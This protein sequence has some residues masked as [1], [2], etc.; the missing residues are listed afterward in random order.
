MP[1]G[2]VGRWLGRLFPQRRVTERMIHALREDMSREHKN[3]VREL[4]EIRRTAE[5]SRQRIESALAAHDEAL[6]ALPELQARIDR[7]VTAYSHDAK[8]ATRLNDFRRSVDR[9]QVLAHVTR[10]V[11]RARLELSPCPYLVVE[12]VFPED[13]YDRLVESLPPPVFFEKTND[14]RDEMPV[15]FSTTGIC[16]ALPRKMIAVACTSPSCCGV[17]SISN[18]CDSWKISA[19]T[20]FLRSCCNKK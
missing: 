5:Q 19:G 1:D 10:A 15:P 4:R 11:E 20:P 8:S 12:N 3:V 16:G 6:A 18:F 14:L 2:L 13:I 7:C 9:Q 17:N